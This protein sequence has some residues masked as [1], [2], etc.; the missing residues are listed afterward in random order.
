MMTPLDMLNNYL[1]IYMPVFVTH[2]EKSNG[3]YK[4]TLTENDP[5]AKLRKIVVSNVPEYSIL[6]NLQEYSKLNIGNRLGRIIRDAHGIFKCCDFLL[7]SADG[8]NLDF[9]YIEMKSKAIVPSDIIEKFNGASCFM[10]Y[11][12]AVI[13]YFFDAPIPKPVSP[14]ISYALLS[15]RNLNKASTVPPITKKNKYRKSLT[16]AKYIHRK[17]GSQGI[18]PYEWFITTE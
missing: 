3:N 15:W 10:E 16:P 6:L 1:K 18:V 17:I 11:C 8:A 13:D 14:R 5:A 2:P 12:R 9:V 7:I 4:F